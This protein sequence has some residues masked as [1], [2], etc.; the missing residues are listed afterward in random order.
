MGP[1]LTR[2]E[3]LNPIVALMGPIFT[4]LRL[5][6]LP[7][8]RRATHNYVGINWRDECKHPLIRFD[9]GGSLLVQIPLILVSK[10][11]AEKRNAVR[12]WGVNANID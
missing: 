3:I 10:H 5:L 2:I 8:D 7:V 1:I 4:R 6:P 11:T 9:W 12:I